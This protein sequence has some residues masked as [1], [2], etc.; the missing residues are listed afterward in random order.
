MGIETELNLSP[1][2]GVA[3]RRLKHPLLADRFSAVAE[4]PPGLSPHPEAAGKLPC[5]HRLRLDES[6]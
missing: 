2:P 1:T 3:S 5:G 4:L 6:L